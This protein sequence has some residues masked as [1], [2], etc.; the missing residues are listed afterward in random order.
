VEVRSDRRWQFGVDPPTLWAAMSDI[1]S[2]RTWWPWLARFDADA[3]EEGASW[4]C[5]V[6][7]PLPYVLRF[8]IHLDVVDA[9]HH[10]EATIDGD[11]AGTAR[12]TIEPDGDGSVL[13]LESH[14]APANAFLRGVARIAAP[15]V[16]L[17]HDWV[18]DT[19]A[20][21]FRRRALG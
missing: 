12:L 14:L 21:Q 4:R 8:G 3:F 5:T 17:G 9:P 15:V 16:R 18:L 7:P 13:R 10:A 6:Q 20:G 11:I 2:Y 1:S 19:G